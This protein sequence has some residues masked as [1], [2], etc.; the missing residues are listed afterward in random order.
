MWLGK[1]WSPQVI[2]RAWR[3]LGLFLRQQSVIS[4]N[5]HSKTALKFVTVWIKSL[6]LPSQ[7][8]DFGHFFRPCDWCE[9][10][11]HQGASDNH[12]PRTGHGRASADSRGSLTEKHV[13]H[14]EGQT[15]LRS[16]HLENMDDSG[17]RMK[18]RKLKAS[19][20]KAITVGTTWIFSIQ[21]G[22]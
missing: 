2:N 17:K 18:S 9:E 15:S 7:L 5:I 22:F 10:T 16:A 19:H 3:V 11:R 12:K 14:K 20:V 8:K 1:L 13:Y 4:W 6:Q 21:E